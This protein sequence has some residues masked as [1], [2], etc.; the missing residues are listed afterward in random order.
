[1][2]EV[3]DAADVAEEEDTRGA[4][5]RLTTGGGGGG[6]GG[7]GITAAGGGGTK[8]VAVCVF[9]GESSNESAFVTGASTGAS[10]NKSSILNSP[11][12]SKFGPFLAIFFVFASEDVILDK[13]Q[14]LKRS[15][16]RSTNREH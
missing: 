5:P 7:G 10:Q 4:S 3:Y 16:K 9:V 14:S 2:R 8:V 15:K 6:G 13:E 11:D 1:M 12:S